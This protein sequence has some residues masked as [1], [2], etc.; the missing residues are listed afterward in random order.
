MPI[1]PI[2]PRD[3]YC[4]DAAGQDIV[5]EAIYLYRANIMFK[6]YKVEGP[7]DKVIVFL[8]CYIQKCLEQ[9]QRYPEHDKAVRI[10]QEIASDPKA[11]D[12]KDKQHVLHKLGQ[13]ND[14]PGLA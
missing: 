10:V 3:T 13:L 8:T 11:F 5:D 2:T 9:I 14:Q 1:Y 7:A 4:A 12:I 6:N